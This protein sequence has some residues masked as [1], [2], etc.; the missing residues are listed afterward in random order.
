[1][2]TALLHGFIGPMILRE[3]QKRRAA[4]I[5]IGSHGHSAFYDLVVGSTASLVLKRA[6]CP[7]LVVPS[8]RL[9]RRK[10]R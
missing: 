8:Q 2:E 10:K 1:V 4:Y 3:A 7:V 9:T 5:V 6:A